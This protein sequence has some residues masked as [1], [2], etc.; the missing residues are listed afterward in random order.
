MSVATIS[1]CILIL[2]QYKESHVTSDCLLVCKRCGKGTFLQI[3]SH[4]ENHSWVAA[5]IAIANCSIPATTCDRQLLSLV[6]SMVTQ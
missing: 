4:M 6:D 1:G 5:I 3:W 2:N